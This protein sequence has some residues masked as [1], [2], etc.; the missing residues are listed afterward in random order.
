MIKTSLVIVIF[1]IAIALVSCEKKQQ[2]TQ[3]EPEKQ[4]EGISDI[5]KRIDAYAPTVIKADLSQLND[6][7]VK[8]LE[9]L[10]EA[11]KL[12]DMIFWRKTSPSSLAVRDSL[13]QIDTPEAKEYLEYV[14]INYGPYDGIYDN[15]RFVG[16]GPEK[17]PAG[18]AFYPTDMSKD[19][20]EQYIADNPKMKDAL[21]SQYTVVIRDGANLKPIPY[22]TYYKEVSKL[23]D[24][25]NQAAGLADNPSLKRYLELRSKAINEDDYF[26]SD[27]AWMDLKD[28]NID[29][30]IGPIE[31]YEDAIFNYKTAY[32]AVVMI[33]DNEATGEL[34]MFQNNIDEFEHRLPYDKK[35]IRESAGKGN[36]LQI[37]NV[38]YFGGDC[39]RGVKTIAA[40]LPNDPRVHKTKGAKKSMYKNMME[41]KF[42]KIVI[43]ISKIILDP[44]LLQ[45]VDSKSFTSFVTL[46]EVSHTLGRG[47][48]Y[49][50]DKLT[51][52]KALK[53][54]YSAIEECKADIVGM[55]NIKNMLDMKLIDAD[56]V[57]RTIVTFVAGLYRS[58]RFG[59]EE[60]HGRSN[61]IQLNYL[62]DNGAIAKQDDGTYKINDDLFFDAVAGLARRL[63]TI[64]AEGDYEAAGKLIADYGQM[65]TATEA[66]IESLKDVPRDLNT[67]YEFVDKMNK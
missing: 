9:K 21:E 50:N 56:Y 3:Q 8:L 52:R 42:Q 58:I 11:G 32:E 59:I 5:Q 43:P 4:M 25:L 27:M 64:E 22:H 51:V 39:Q 55:Y 61:M 67:T 26:E 41:A 31:N 35:Y 28:N 12:A 37:V 53:E 29:V 38:V 36:I 7:Q 60:A 6:R 20:F 44:S 48:V 24:L 30:V 10:V 57:K 14:M 63:L 49:G 40:S 2:Q 15:E 16:N 65:N 17:R 34:E 13:R 54:R 46:H 1:A 33:K 62:R 47:Y 23:A 66:E 19:E 45:Y 18:G